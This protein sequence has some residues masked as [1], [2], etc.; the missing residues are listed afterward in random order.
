MQSQNDP[1]YAI[2]NG[3]KILVPSELKE[4]VF[5]AKTE[6]IRN[7]MD[8]HE[9]RVCLILDVSASMQG[10]NEFFSHPTK[11]NRVQKLIN[12]ALALAFLFDDNQLGTDEAIPP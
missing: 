4:E 2:I 1:N 7:G 10:N 12:K 6:I 5:S 9:A 8:S 11:G 3:R